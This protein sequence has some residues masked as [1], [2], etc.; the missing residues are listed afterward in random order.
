M[1]MMDNGKKIIFTCSSPYR[2]DGKTYMVLQS[3]SMYMY[4]DLLTGTGIGRL[5]LLDTDKDGSVF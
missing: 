3:K 4:Y 5:S 2:T 1:E